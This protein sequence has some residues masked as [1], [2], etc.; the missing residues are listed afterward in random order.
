VG[1]SR[2]RA[3]D[4]TEREVTVLLADFANRLERAVSAEQARILRLLIERID[5]VPDRCLRHAACCPGFA[6]SLQSGGPEAPA[7]AA[8]E[9]FLEAAVALVRAHR[10][11]R[12]IESGRAK[13]IID[14]AEREGVTTAYVW[15]L[16]PLTCL[17]P[18]IVEAIPHRRQPKGLRLAEIL[19]NG[20]LGWEE[21]WR[22]WQLG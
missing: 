5:V 3:R 10:W 13:S 4:I 19:R 18:D 22:H 17:A 12:R 14:F 9:S 11:Q 20:P 1:S 2:D 8:S 15:R 6:A 7:P 21:Q 16:Q